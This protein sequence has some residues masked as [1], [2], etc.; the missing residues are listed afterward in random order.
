MKYI[1]IISII[2]FLIRFFFMLIGSLKEKSKQKKSYIKEYPFVSIIVPARNEED[3]IEKCLLELTESDYPK[4]KY[5]ILPVNDRSDDSTGKIIDNL[6]DLHSNI[7]PVHVTENNKHKNLKGKP[8]ALQSGIEKS[9]GKY[10]LMTDADCLVNKNWIKTTV[11]NFET[12][13]YD[14]I[15]SFTLIS[16]N[17]IFDKIQAVEWIYMHT[18][19]SAGVGN[20]T[21]LGCYGNNLSIR[22]NMYE[23]IGGYPNIEFSVTEDLA[24]EKSVFE[25]KGKVHYHCDYDSTVV[26]LPCKT[27]SEYL[28]Q[29]KRWAVGGTGLGWKATYFVFASLAMWTSII[30]SGIYQMWIWLAII[31]IIRFLADYLLIDSSLPKLKQQRLRKW[32]LPSVIFFTVMELIVPFTLLTG[33]VKW[34]GQKF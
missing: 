20:N 26:T 3:K 32:I 27:M 19:A 22:K 12:N 7:K 34:K 24:L 23:N 5:E 17:R 2:L 14:L 18:M 25:H 11:Q 13:D 8:G 4:E 33:K 15:P 16:G 6:A 30:I 21:P 1:F 10:L 31:G 29:K 9:Q 28:K